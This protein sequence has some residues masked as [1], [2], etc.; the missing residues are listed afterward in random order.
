[1]SH[2]LWLVRHAQPLIDKGICYGQLDVAADAQS[3]QRAALGLA[4]ALKQNHSR[5]YLVYYSGLQRTQQ[6]A[7]ALQEYFPQLSM[8]VD[9]RLKEMHFGQW[10]GHA[11]QS[12]PKVEI[13]TWTYDFG[14][15]QFGGVESCQDVLTRVIA[16]YSESVQLSQQHQADIVW[17][18][19]AGVIRALQ[20]YLHRGKDT[21]DSAHQWPLEAPDFGAWICLDLPHFSHFSHFK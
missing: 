13:D 4:Q 14:M 7:I 19:H 6:L 12:I 20:Y 2:K 9:L 10:E 18:T 16:A 17:I 8:T 15:H 1:M 3:T 21:I 5:N 11:W